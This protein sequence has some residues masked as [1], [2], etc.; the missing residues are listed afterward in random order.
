MCDLRRLIIIG[1]GGHAKVCAEI[2]QLNG[3][4]DIIYLDDNDN[5]TNKNLLFGCVSG[6]VNDIDKFD[7]DIFVAIGD[8]VIREKLLN[9]ITSKNRDVISLVHPSAVVSDYVT[10]GAGVVIMAGAVVNPS[11][12]IEDG[13]IIN[14]C[15]SID[16]DCYIGSNS[17]V[18]VGAHICGTVTIGNKCWIGAGATVLNNVNITDNVTVGAGAVVL[19]DIFEQGTYVGVPVRKLV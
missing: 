11:V 8:S 7:G 6:K 3:Y 2:A 14:T 18:A 16:H 13:S 5:I 19:K 12:V 4:K 1:A 10:L 17:H 15:S 9:Y